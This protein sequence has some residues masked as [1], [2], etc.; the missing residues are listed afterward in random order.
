MTFKKKSC[1]PE[2]GSNRRAE[3]FPGS[4][5]GRSILM[6]DRFIYLVVWDQSD[7]ELGVQ[8]RRQSCAFGFGRGEGDEV[9]NV[10]S[11]GR[12]A[13]HLGLVPQ[14]QKRGSWHH[15]QRFWCSRLVRT[16]GIRCMTRTP[17]DSEAQPD[18]ASFGKEW[19]RTAFQ[20]KIAL[21]YLGPLL[22]WHW[23]EYWFRQRLWNSWQ[24]SFIIPFAIDKADKYSWYLLLRKSRSRFWWTHWGS[25][26]L[27]PEGLS[28]SR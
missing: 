27:S 14:G 24:R 18:S 17:G 9:R 10:K 19:K 2:K 21:V 12:E 6:L 1:V 20:G 13:K 23:P 3:W 7:K 28:A 4:N 22:Y 11:M 15:S 25:T 8:R 16:L 5:L 26:L